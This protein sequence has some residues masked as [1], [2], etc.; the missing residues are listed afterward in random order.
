MLPVDISHV[1]F[2]TVVVT[3]GASCTVMSTVTGSAHASSGVNVYDKVPAADVLI[4]DG[5]HDPFT[6]LSEVVGNAVGVEPTQNGPIAPN[7]G[8]TAGLTVTTMLIGL[9]HSVASGVN[10]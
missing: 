3:K 9:A 7:T 1:G 4:V 8:V 5:L 2:V 10:V 6:P